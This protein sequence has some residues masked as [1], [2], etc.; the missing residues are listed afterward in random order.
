MNGHHKQP[1]QQSVEQQKQ[2]YC[3]KWNNHQTNLQ[4]VFSRL[5][6][7]ETFTDVTIACEGRSL[8]AHKLVLSAC[9]SY[10]EQLFVM[11]ADKSPLVILRDIS[12]DNMKAIIDFMY[13]G[14]ISVSQE[15]LSSLINTADALK[16]KGLAEV[17]NGSGGSTPRE[18]TSSPAPVPAAGP[19]SNSS[20]SSTSTAPAAQK[21]QKP[22]PAAAPIPGSIPLSSLLAPAS[23]SPTTKA[24]DI[25]NQERQRGQLVQAASS[26]SSVM[27]IPSKTTAH[28]PS[29]WP[30]QKPQQQQ[31]RDTSSP[32]QQSEES[33]S[34]EIS[35]EFGDVFQLED[36]LATGLGRDS[37]W[38]L[39]ATRK[40]LAAV[41]DHR[42]DMKL[43]AKLLGV[44]YNTIYGRYREVYGSLS[45]SPSSASSSAPPSSSSSTSANAHIGGDEIIKMNHF[46][47]NGGA[48]MAFWDLPSTKQVLEAIRDKS[49]ELK[50]AAEVLGVSYGTLYGRYRENY[51]YLKACWKQ[52]T[53]AVRKAS[54][55]GGSLWEEP[56]TLE[57]LRRLS[58][59][60][61]TMDQ[62]AER[63]NV[64]YYVLQYQLSLMELSLPFSA[65]QKTPISSS[66]AGKRPGFL[67]DCPMPG[68]KLARLSNGEEDEV[69]G[70]DDSIEEHQEV[71]Q[72]DEDGLDEEDD[73]DLQL[74][75]VEADQIEDRLSPRSSSPHS[76]PV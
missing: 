33:G 17:S 18:K 27:N 40:V 41:R 42:L 43:G 8:Q 38:K 14:E 63:L 44:S 21:V 70:L 39:D 59:G 23:S 67:Q 29:T 76:Q 73:E 68:L 66:A 9:S 62:V 53:G 71:R 61:V 49:M 3:L 64:D 50:H 45:Y 58:V 1:Q 65:Q 34:R 10:F 15:Q 55:S 4:R 69:I 25:V 37:F 75:I 13:N 52:Q 51:G 26:P 57:L 35:E 11:H 7:S 28:L 54:V 12:Y 5:L 24:A 2:Q 47:K 19:A 72:E 16:V 74:K 56:D 32:A 46:V 31:Q 48:R 60:E 36:Y 22:V 20:S 30:A 6:R